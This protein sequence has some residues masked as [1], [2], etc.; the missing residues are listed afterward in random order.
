M[1]SSIAE[2]LLPN[3]ITSKGVDAANSI[4]GIAENIPVYGK[5]ATLAKLGL[6]A[7]DSLG[8]SKLA[9]IKNDQAVTDTLAHTGGGY[10]NFMGQWNEAKDLSGQRVGLF[11][12]KSALNNKIYDA[13][14]KMAILQNIIGKK[15]T[16]D[17]LTA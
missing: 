4:L 7:I 6:N 11:T 1:G 13:N 8:A 5:F 14:Y 17:L 15:R 2:S 12:G 9:E 10:E 16:D 3:R